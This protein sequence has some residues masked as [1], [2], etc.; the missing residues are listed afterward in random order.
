MTATRTH[1]NWHTW[2]G[3]ARRYR[4]RP[5]LSP[6]TAPNSKPPFSA[7]QWCL[8]PPLFSSR[9][10]GM[11]QT[12]MLLL[13]FKYGNFVV[14]TDT[15]THQ[16]TPGHSPPHSHTIRHSLGVA[17]RLHSTSP[18]SIARLAWPS[19]RGSC[20]PRHP[21]RP[22]PLLALLVMP[23]Y[24]LRGS[25]MIVSESALPLRKT[26]SAL[27]LIRITSKVAIGVQGSACPRVRCVGIKV[28]NS[29]IWEAIELKF[30]RK[31][32]FYTKYDISGN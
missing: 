1:T 24:T 15:R 22:F 12:E 14:S 21:F 30:G 8:Q 6:G 28:N 11:R 27:I 31:V 25:S 2:H 19:S 18:V 26:F 20:H 23:S 10:I 17:H 29:I 16:D 4:P 3:A 9:F 32:H 13:C 7:E 5:L